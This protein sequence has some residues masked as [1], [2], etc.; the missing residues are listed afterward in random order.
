[1]ENAK[2]YNKI[3]LAIGLT[4]TFLTLV[5]LVVLI[6]TPLGI[7]IQDVAFQISEWFFKTTNEYFALLIFFGIIGLATGILFFP[8]TY[9]S[10]FYLE[11]KFNLSNQTFWKWIWEDLKGLLVSLV[12]GVPLLLLFFYL[13]KN[14]PENWWRILATVLFLFSV[15]LA[16]LAPTLIFPI[17]YKFTPLDD[18]GLKTKIKELCEKVG[19]RFS[20]IFKFD[21][22]KNTKKANA[23]F[24][25]IRKSKRI[26]LSDTLLNGF[27]H[28]EILS[29]FAHELGHY[30]R[31][32]ILKNMI[33]GLVL[34]YLGLFLAAELYKFLLPQFDFSSQHQLAALPLLTL[35]LIIYG[36]TTMPIQNIISRKFEYEAD[37]FALVSTQNRDAFISTMEKLAITNLADKTPHPIVEFLFYSHPSIEKR[38][39]VATNRKFEQRN[40]YA[41]QA[42]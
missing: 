35:V 41:P 40:N 27:T 30:R 29:V 4:E 23:G 5:L 19:Q 33:I 6:L 13:I 8:L 37:E 20:G 42:I 34:S 9:Y 39:A 1:M 22:S 21:L 12:L 7:Y 18:E 10:D 16:R 11:H 25:G 2:K 14:Y 26:I 17:F 3:K 31:K 24:T 36:F 15:V 38:I 28:D 32:H